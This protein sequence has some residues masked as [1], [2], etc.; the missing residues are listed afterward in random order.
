MKDP[1]DAMHILHDMAVQCR[2]FGAITGVEVELVKNEDSSESDWSVHNTD[3]WVWCQ[4]TPFLRFCGEFG[5]CIVAGEVEH[6]QPT[7]LAS[8]VLKWKRI[9]YTLMK[10]DTWM[11]YGQPMCDYEVAA[12]SSSPSEILGEAAKLIVSD[13]ASNYYPI[14]NEEDF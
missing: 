3:N 9:E 11:E 2:C 5:P 10:P 14:S 12:Q 13:I 8:R 4:D 7:L 1:I 6:T